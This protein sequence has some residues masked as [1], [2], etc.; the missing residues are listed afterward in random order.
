[1]TKNSMEPVCSIFM[2]A[3]S[4]SIKDKDLEGT[5]KICPQYVRRKD[6]NDTIGR[7]I[8]LLPEEK[9]DSCQHDRK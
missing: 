1:M 9:A 7:Y 8:V 4:T 3:K 5:D 6:T 2:F